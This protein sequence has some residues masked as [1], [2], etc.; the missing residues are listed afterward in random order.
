MFLASFSLTHIT[1]CALNPFPV[2]N[3]S[4]ITNNFP[5]S[6]WIYVISPII[7][8]I[9]GGLMKRTDYLDDIIQKIKSKGQAD[10]ALRG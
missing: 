4:L 1:G 6:Q 9:I 8:I 7:G 5:K 3:G 10:E 2:I